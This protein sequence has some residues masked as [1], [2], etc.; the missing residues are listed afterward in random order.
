MAAVRSKLSEAGGRRIASTI[1]VVLFLGVLTALLWKPLAMIVVLWFEGALGLFDHNIPPHRIHDF[2][3]SLL[4]W[5][6]AVGM[7]AQ[8]RRPRE[9]VA[10]QLMA[11]IPWA[12]LVLAF[13]LTNFWR[14][15]PFV[16]IFGG[17][18]LLATL[19]HPAGRDLLTPFTDPRVNRVLLALVVIAAVPLIAF[20]GTSVGIQTGAIEQAHDHDH[21]EGGASEEVH[22]EHV[23]AGHFAIMAA[24]SFVLIGVGLLAS[25][26][27][28]GW[29]LPAWFAGFMAVVFGVASIAFQ[30]IASSGGLL[31]GGAAILWGVGFVAAAELTQDAEAPTLL[32]AREA[33][34]AAK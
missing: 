29:W 14:P 34:S 6:A 25:L 26:Q 1:V 32:G 8:L 12:G 28:V 33:S 10:G 15:I 23:E 22:E 4:F 5:T 21:S 3:F 18:T 24:F 2:A 20:A 30:D 17:L 9:N 19:L 31:W 27:P 13:A 11:L 7:L 16:A